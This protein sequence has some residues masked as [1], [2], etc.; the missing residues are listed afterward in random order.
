MGTATAFSG[1]ILGDVAI[2]GG[3]SDFVGHP[4]FQESTLIKMIWEY[5]VPLVFFGGIFSS[6]GYVDREKCR[7]KLSRL[8]RGSE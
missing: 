2:L 8:E 6:G 3:V 1:V 5:T 7:T 4:I